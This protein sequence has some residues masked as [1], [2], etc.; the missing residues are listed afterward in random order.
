MNR[1]LIVKESQVP[2]LSTSAVSLL[3]ESEVFKQA[4]NVCRPEKV[5]FEV[6]ERLSGS[7]SA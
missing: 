1:T 3:N 6:M 2:F 4:L 5:T 7:V